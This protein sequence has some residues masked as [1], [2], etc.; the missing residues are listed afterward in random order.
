MAR[1]REG[2]S[3][4]QANAA[5]VP[6][7]QGTL[8]ATTSPGMPAERRSVFLGRRT[9]LLSAQ[10]GFSRV[11][12]QFESS[13]WLLL[14]LAALLFAVACV[15]AGNML[16]ARG[17]GRRRELVVRLA[18]GASRRRL[19]RQM[20]IEAFVWTLLGAG[21]GLILAQW[22]AHG[23][24]RIMSTTTEP[25]V[26]DVSPNGRMLIAAFLLT[27]LSTALSAIVSALRATRLDASHELKSHSA[28]GGLL[29]RAS[30]GNALVAIQVAL[31]VVL[32]LTSVLFSRS[33]MRILGR[34]VGFHRDGLLV[35]S[36]DPLAAGY[37]G[38]GLFTFYQTLLER[39]R[40]MPGIESASLSWYPPISGD[41][42]AW[43]QSIAVDG[44]E[45]L[46]RA[47]RQVYFNA[48]SPG[49]LQ[50]M[51]MRLLRGRDFADRDSNASTKVVLLNESLARRLFADG[52]AIGRKVTIGRNATRK[53]LEVVGIVQDSK[54]QRLQEPARNIAYLPCAQLA[55]LFK[56]TK[57]VAV[58]RSRADQDVRAGIV[59]EVTQLDARVPV[60]LETVSDR[61]AESL[62]KERVLAMLA[63]ALGAIALALACA[64]VF[65]LMAYAVSSRTNEI[66]LRMALGA[67]PAGVLR[68]VLAESTAVAAAGLLLALPLTLWLGRYLRTWLF[69][70]SPFD[71]PSI[72]AAALLMVTLAGVAAL[73]PAVRA[74]RISPV[75]AL[76]A[77]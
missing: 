18:I 15:S 38:P 60:H 12:R 13:L 25:I 8:D 71:L 4:A 11:R 1:L 20:L 66:G 26:L 56:G 23:L 6:V 34:D 55:E 69:E 45:K 41:D 67:A 44:V 2:I 65:G 54:Y 62:V 77:E 68:A 40:Q 10:T 57:L 3:L 28:V 72:A 74:S 36:T 46:D 39:L 58:V 73:I 42:G 49:Y 22:G 30:L 14:G 76:K 24:L 5:F 16:I 21:A 48:I 59:H 27:L 35:V 53:D 75:S 7:W 37:V 63:I 31:T 43:T 52:D 9:E 64:A 50:T 32:L 19:I 33:L 29:R 17:I 61:I 47:D 51:E 70:I